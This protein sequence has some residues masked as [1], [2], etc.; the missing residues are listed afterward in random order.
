MAEEFDVGL[1]TIQRYEKGKSVP[2]GMLLVDLALQGYNLHWLITGDGDKYSFKS[3]SV[4]PLLRDLWEWVEE[5]SKEDEGKK[6]WFRVQLE[7][8]FPSFKEWKKKK[9]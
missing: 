6:E 2:G 5:I 9:K 7:M 3:P 8:S 1:S 4:D